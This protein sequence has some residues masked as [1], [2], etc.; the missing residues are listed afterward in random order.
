MEGGKY[1]LEKFVPDEAPNEE[2]AKAEVIKR[3]EEGDIDGASEIITRFKLAEEFVQSAAKAAMI[4]HL[5]EGEEG[6]IY[7]A[8]KIITTFK[9]AVEFIQSGTQAWVIK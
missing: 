1:D 8:R 6:G 3:L 5:E 7:N 2:A 9:L 4:K